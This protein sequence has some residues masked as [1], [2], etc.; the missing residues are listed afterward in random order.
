MM[1]SCA[2]IA[3]TIRV[4][5]VKA[6]LAEIAQEVAHHNAHAGGDEAAGRR[7]LALR[8]KHLTR[9]L[10]ITSTSIGTVRHNG[11]HVVEVTLS[12]V[13]GFAIGGHPRVWIS[14]VRSAPV[15]G[16]SSLP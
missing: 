8:V 7:Y 12:A 5:Q 15:E 4:T 11:V 13:V 6:A 10:P 1:W 14:V 16:R 2:V 3:T 9:P